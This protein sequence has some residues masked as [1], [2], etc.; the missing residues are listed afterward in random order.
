MV[1]R[2][3]ELTKKGKLNEETLSASTAIPITIMTVR[4][5]YL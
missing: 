3:V 5:C 4:Q 2:K 1:V